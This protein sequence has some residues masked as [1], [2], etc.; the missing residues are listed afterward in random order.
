MH[1]RLALGLPAP[2][3]DWCLTY[4]LHSTLLLLGVWLVTR[5]VA[6]MLAGDAAG[7]V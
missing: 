2:L 7:C 6:R 4:L 1:S 3:Q 5:L